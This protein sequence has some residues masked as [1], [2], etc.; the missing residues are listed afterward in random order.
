MFVIFGTSWKY[1]K[2][3]GGMRIVKV[4]PNCRRDGEF[5]EV[6]PKQYIS[7]YFIPLIPISEKNSLLECPN[8]HKKF[9]IQSD[10]H[11]RSF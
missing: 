6:V 5:Y 2:K 10:D 11:G 8:C 7:L 9:Y 1:K 4:C 3:P